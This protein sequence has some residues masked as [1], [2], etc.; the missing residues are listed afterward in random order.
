MPSANC[1]AFSLIA[2]LP[3]AACSGGEQAGKGPGAISEGEKQAL[4]KAAEMLDA[5]RL[6]DD[7]LPPLGPAEGETPEQTDPR[8]D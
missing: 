5:Q 6:P 8:Q 4:D 3:L 2:A 7:A 1:L